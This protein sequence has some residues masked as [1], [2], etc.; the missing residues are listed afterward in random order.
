M[1]KGPG[2]IVRNNK[3]SSYSVFEL[4]G[5]HCMAAEIPIL[6]LAFVYFANFL[7]SLL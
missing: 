6:I 3:S 4:T 2:K 7:L 1:F 5:V